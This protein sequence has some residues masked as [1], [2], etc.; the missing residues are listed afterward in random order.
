MSNSLRNSHLVF[1]FYDPNSKKSQGN[2][3]TDRHTDRHTHGQTVT[4]DGNIA[5][6]DVD[7][8]F[9]VVMLSPLQLAK[10]VYI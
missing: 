5:S 3:F 4:L 9:F 6:I 7:C 1:E 10:S 8:I 2:L